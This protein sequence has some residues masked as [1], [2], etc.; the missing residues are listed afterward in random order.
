MSK[1]FF[2]CV[3]ASPVSVLTDHELA[4]AIQARRPDALVQLYDCYGGLMYGLAARILGSS[5]EA[6]DLIQEIFLH[7]WQQC[8]YDPERGSFKTFLMVLVRSRCLDRL[9]A[10]TARSR[11]AIRAHFLHPDNFG[12]LL[13]NVSTQE[14]S[15]RVR[16]AL[17]ELP[18]HQRQALEL[19]YFDG[20]SQQEIANKLN[21]P[22][23]TVKSWFRLS[24]TK[25]RRSLDDLIR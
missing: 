2:V 5:Q 16:A 19:S 17:T 20:L 18:D 25:L 4:Q 15:Q 7:L 12:S 3:K 9:R 22:L 1:P 10:Q 13:E 21:V 6:E 14:T 11:T 8:S 23:G 24:F